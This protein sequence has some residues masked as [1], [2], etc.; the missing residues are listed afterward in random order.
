MDKEGKS[1]VP[2]KDLLFEKE[3]SINNFSEILDD[4]EE[5]QQFSMETAKLNPFNPLNTNRL[6]DK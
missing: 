5:K 3:I 4:I 1:I 2:F 6:G